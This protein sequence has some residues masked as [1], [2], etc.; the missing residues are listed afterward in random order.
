MLKHSNWP[1]SALIAALPRKRL[2]SM[3]PILQAS[4]LRGALSEPLRPLYLG[5][6]RDGWLLVFVTGITGFASLAFPTN[7]RLA[8]QKGPIGHLTTQLISIHGILQKS[9]FPS[10][11]QGRPQSRVCAVALGHHRRR[12]FVA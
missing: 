10:H 8:L 6:V 2:P 12:R 3:A 7:R 9:N 4:W 11:L 5:D 1:F